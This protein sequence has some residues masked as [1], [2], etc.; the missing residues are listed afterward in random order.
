MVEEFDSIPNSK[1]ATVKEIG[2]RIVEKLNSDKMRPATKKKWSNVRETL[3][4]KREAITDDTDL[5]TTAIAEFVEAAYRPKL[6]A[7][8][9]INSINLPMEGTDSIQIPFENLMAE[10][11]A[12]N[13][14]GTLAEETTEYGSETVNISYV[15]HRTSFTQQLLD[16]ANID[17]LAR[18][19]SQIG[20]AIGRKVD[21]DII[22]EL[23]AVTNPIDTH[24][25]DN[26]NYNYLGSATTASWSDLIDTIKGVK[27]NYGAPDTILMGNN[28]WAQIHKD[29]DVKDALQFG[30]GPASE[31]EQVQKFFGMDLLTSTQIPT[32]AAFF[33]DSN[34]L[35]YFVDGT[36]IKNYDGRVS[37]TVKQ[38]VLGI[39]GYGVRVTLPKAVYRLEQSKDKPT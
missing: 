9:V 23:K 29:P 7:Q 4:R 26:S 36:G 13:S 8:D 5:Y 25:G 39:K 16:K 35:G 24:Y 34:R 30:T 18:R 6:L 1:Q 28:L 31:L 12:V 3:N 32:D 21:T 2:K 17:L 27:A 15:G 19:L 33:V 22:A 10:A 11:S 14:N 38:E 37:N 20:D